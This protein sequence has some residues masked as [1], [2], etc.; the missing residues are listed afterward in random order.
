MVYKD[1]RYMTYGV[2]KMACLRIG[3]L[4]AAFAIISIEMT[5]KR[6]IFTRITRESLVKF[7]MI[8]IRHVGLRHLCTPCH[9]I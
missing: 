9:N 2:L 3:Y 6:L 1:I 8:K 7:P 4:F 5:K